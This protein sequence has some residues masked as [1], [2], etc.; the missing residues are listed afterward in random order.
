[1]ARSQRTVIEVK[2]DRCTRVEERAFMPEGDDPNLPAFK[3]AMPGVSV[4]FGDLC[5]PCSRSVK[6]HLEQIGKK[7]DSPS[8]FRTAKEDK[9]PEVEISVIEEPVPT[10]KER[11]DSF[12]PAPESRK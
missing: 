6:N 1:M 2:C 11:K 7:L 9:S 5:L 10:K 3:G 8:P 12:L 4:E